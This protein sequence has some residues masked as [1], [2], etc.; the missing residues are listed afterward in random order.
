M[1]QVRVG[2]DPS[3]GR[4]DG[5]AVLK[6]GALISLQDLIKEDKVA[7]IFHLHLRGKSELDCPSPWATQL[8]THR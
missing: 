8:G 3:E 7:N 2:K 1:D 4:S 5:M 6:F